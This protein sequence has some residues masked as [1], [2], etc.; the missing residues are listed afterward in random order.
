MYKFSGKISI[1]KRIGS[2]FNSKKLIE[3][4]RFFNYYN[5]FQIMITNGD[6]GATTLLSFL[7]TF[8]IVNLILIPF[9]LSLSM[10]IALFLAVIVSRKLYYF[11]IN[12]YKFQYLNSL[13]YLD[14]IYQDFLVIKNS[15]QS[16]FDAI[17]FIANSN[18]PIISKNFQDMIFQI[19]NGI[20]PEEVLFNYINSV[21]HQTF[22]ERMLNLLSYDMKT[23]DKI[24]INQDFSLELTSKYQ[25][26][27]K[28]LDTRITILISVNIF[29]PILTITLF[30]YKQL[31]N[32]NI[33]T[34]SCVFALDNEKI[35]I[36]KRIFHFRRR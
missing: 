4:I 27:T 2:K 32:F 12:D 11:I 16:I 28:Q 25:E 23:K 24:L 17:E 5:N 9:N 6:I 33:I 21:S 20:P 19:N 8:I 13:Q 36:E 26:Y 22:K 14:L 30:S 31:F 34:I 7:L 10:L 18:Y 35:I 1:L 3:A 29:L 15:T